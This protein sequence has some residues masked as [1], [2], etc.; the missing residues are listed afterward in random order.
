MTRL[1]V[2]IV[3]LGLAGCSTY[4]LDIPQGNIVT[5]DMAAKL[6]P[7]MTR[8][9]VRFALGSPM[10]ADPFH[11]DRWDYIYRT[12]EN[13]KSKDGRHLTVWFKGDILERWEGTTLPAAKPAAP[14][15]G[16]PTPGAP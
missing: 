14:A 11:A 8:A 4:K 9:Q 2:L 6:K 3:W 7:G 15:P 10:V 5:E 12:T 13:G 1:L 16:A